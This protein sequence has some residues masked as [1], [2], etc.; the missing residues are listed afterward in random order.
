MIPQRVKLQGFLCYKDQQEIHFDGASLWI[1]SG[2]NGSGKST[3]FDALTYAIFGHHRG[4]SQQAQELIN[5]DCD[6][7][8]IEFDFHLDGSLYRVRRTLRRNARGGATGTQQILRQEAGSLSN[9]STWQPVEGTGQK[10]EFDAWIRDHIGLDYETFTSSVLLLQGKAEKLLDSTAKGRFEVLAGI[11]D[12]ERYERLHRL[13]DDKR[14]HLDKEFE[15]LQIHLGATPRVEPAEWIQLEACLNTRTAAREE[16]ESAV[17]YWQAVEY[18]ARRWVEWQNRLASARQRWETAQRLLA[19]ATTIQ[20]DAQRFQELKTVLPTLQNVVE[21]KREAH[22]AEERA[23]Q[24][25][26][27]KQQLVA[28][29]EQQDHLLAQLRQKRTGLESTIA[30]DDQS[31]QEVSNKLVRAIELLGRVQEYDRQASD[32]ARLEAEL[33]RLPADSAGTLERARTRQEQ[34][35]LLTAAVP[36]LDRL[37]ARREELRKTIAEEQSARTALQVIIQRGEKLAAEVKLLKPKAEDATR[38]RQQADERAAETRALFQQAQRTLHEF[39]QLE[40]ARTCRQ[41]GQPLTAD[42]FAEELRRRERELHLLTG[43]QQDAAKAQEAAQLAETQQREQL[44]RKEKDCQEARDE[45]REQRNLAEQSKLHAERLV[46]DLNQA[47]SEL[48]RPYRDRV[49]ETI[50]RDWLMVDYPA[51]GECEAL[52][53]EVSGLP[54]MQRQVRE[55]EECHKQWDR[56][57]VQEAAIRQT[58]TRLRQELPAEPQTVLQEHSKLVAEQSALERTL[59]AK[60]A[61]LQEAQRE[62]DRGSREREQMQL[63]VGDLN[64]RLHAEETAR[65]Q[66]EQMAARLRKELPDTWQVEVERTGMKE[67]FTW[68]KERDDL[69]VSGIEDRWRQLHQAQQGADLLREEYETLARQQESFRAEARL[70]PDAAVRKLLEAKQTRQQC[71]AALQEARQQKAHLEKL[72]QQRGQ[73]EDETQQVE[74]ELKHYEHLAELLGRKR[75]QLHLVRRAE[76]Q[77]VDH[78]N[79]VLDR[80][81]GGQLYLRLCGEADG[82]GAS[83]K[84]LELEAYNRSTGE[85]PINVAFL[86]GSQKFRV[87]VSL[88]LGI[89]QYASRQHRPLESVI[90]DEGF[91]C[92]DRYGRQVMIQELQ[93]LRGHLQCILLVSHQ[94][95]FA[96]AFADGY[97]FELAEGAT[98]V[99]RIQ[100]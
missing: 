91:G 76:R 51:A 8:T 13:A 65:Q 95:E 5:K 2:L 92:L 44:A 1:L 83:D 78:A 46:L 55:A 45:F 62:L 81:S 41:C 88:A 54:S 34:L 77:V 21:Q 47:F 59:K 64:S 40:G 73:L 72:R 27:A 80:L 87:A 97:H 79:A 67:L 24:A 11:V 35:Q 18:E 99:K 52:R 82:E 6:G 75:L 9:Q 70:G 60:R 85:K 3:V 53:R 16:A 50:P 61:E 14:R 42:H 37:A 30:R 93:N 12:L 23:R 43:H 58:L 48:P 68:Q 84:A 25:S 17:E 89:G 90:I 86:S 74:G 28:R 15:R 10:R 100:R 49:G 38:L 7:L 36:I 96:E 26:V 69:A 31:T 56:L 22:N 66:H 94:E 57:K 32:L 33:G 98:R 71:E 4:G 20:G 63:Q 19:D 39:R 29:L